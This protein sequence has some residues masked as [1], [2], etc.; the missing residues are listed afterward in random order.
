[1]A[2]LPI[3]TYG[4]P[5]LTRKNDK[6]KLI[7]PEVINLI[8][9]MIE[10]M[11]TAKGVGL[12]APQVGVNKQIIVVDVGDVVGKHELIVL[13]NPELLAWEGSEEL[14]EGCL[15]CPNVSVKMKRAQR[16]TL[17]GI[18]REGEKVIREDSGY[19]AR[20]LQHELDH[21][22]GKL[23]VDSVGFLKKLKLKRKL[24]KRVKAGI[25]AEI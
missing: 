12:A 19:Q 18:N 6:V 14:E 24:K 15:S 9:D 8:N 2:V 4:N 1:M 7:T 16:I 21:L 22:M 20:A 23:I 5:C 10:T 25:K 13:V 11:Y 3:K 17:Q